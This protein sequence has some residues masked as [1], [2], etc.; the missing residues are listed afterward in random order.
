MTDHLT[1]RV[2]E[3]RQPSKTELDRA[4]DILSHPY[5]RR[6]LTTLVEANPRDEDELSPEH[7]QAADEDLEM[8]T[9]QLFHVHLPKLEAA[10]YIEWD[11]ETGAITRGPNFDEVAPLVKLMRNH[12]DELPADW[13]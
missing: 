4:F 3:S 10:E 8:F 11:R 9:T 12:P 1:S 5:R 7:L 6:I 13:P 2:G